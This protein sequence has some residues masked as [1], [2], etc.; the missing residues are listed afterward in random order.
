M[1]RNTH[2]FLFGISPRL[3]VP[4][5]HHFLATPPKNEQPVMLLLKRY[6]TIVHRY[7]SALKEDKITILR[8]N[9]TEDD[10]ITLEHTHMDAALGTV[11]RSIDSINLEIYL[12]LCGHLLLEGKQAQKSKHLGH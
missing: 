4:N 11:W 9:V 10:K 7:E 6:V 1:E 12:Q 5:C 8:Q 3:F 2:H